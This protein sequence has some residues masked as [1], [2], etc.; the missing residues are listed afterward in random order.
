MVCSGDA[1]TPRRW[2]KGGLGGAGSALLLL[3]ACN[4]VIE[5]TASGDLP[6]AEPPGREPLGGLTPVVC[7]PARSAVH[8]PRVW[9]LTREQYDNTV[10]EL[11]GNS[12]RLAAERLPREFA[13]AGFT[14]GADQLRVRDTEAVQLNIMARALAEETVAER[15][16]HVFPCSEAQLLEADCKARFI[17]EFGERAFRRA[18]S[19]DEQER[20]LALYDVAAAK[21]DGRL[22]VTAVLEAMLQSPKF[23]FRSELTD[24]APNENG[25]ARLTLEET[26][27]SLAYSLTNSPPD[28]ELLAAVADGSLAEP[29]EVEAQARRLTALP[30]ARATL[31]G[32]LEQLFEYNYLPE[33]TKNAQLFPLFAAAKPDMAEEGRRFFEH[34]A[35][36]S[37]GTLQELLTS[38]ES[39]VT[40]ALAELYG[41][42]VEGPG[43]SQVTLDPSQRA[44][45]LTLSGVMAHLAVD[46]RTSPVARGEFVRKRLLC[47]TI[48]EPPAGVDIT[49]PEL[50]PGM[51]G[52]DALDA[53]TSGSPCKECHALMNPVGFG[54]ES[55]DSIGA[56]RTHDNDVLLDDSG[57]L[58]NT[59]DVDGPFRGPVE[60][61]QRLATS[62]QVSECFAIQAFRYAA[63]RA[64]DQGDACAVADL[65]E[66][67]AA[68]KYDLRELLVGVVLAET[69]TYRHLAE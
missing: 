35:F 10:A 3:S 28:A 47:Q 51:T 57:E 49:F 58:T 48:A 54:F 24:G 27:T 41:V 25:W 1:R 63:G 15:L 53:R 64:D 39:F 4:A 19:E 16:S 33:I 61:A 67:F 2:G 55:L 18:L 26:A 44:G 14:N 37:T 40:P 5:G 6:G 46:N 45:A 42:A 21:Q 69:F 12:Q 38:A 56:H 13:S 59:R 9:R 31:A 8:F 36:E 17:R 32:F 65:V 29:A 66:R 30:A 34:V 43:F 52:R 62:E 22:A 7:D 20:Y 68:A 50:D 23:L 60:L 11:L